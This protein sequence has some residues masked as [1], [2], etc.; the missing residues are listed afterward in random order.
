MKQPK[1]QTPY[2]TIIY[3]MIKLCMIYF[4]NTTFTQFHTETFYFPN[5]H[6]YYIIDVLLLLLIL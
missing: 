1:K 5:H 4:L 3:V 2:K 6:D